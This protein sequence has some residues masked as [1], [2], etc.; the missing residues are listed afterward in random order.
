MVKDSTGT[1]CSY[2]IGAKLVAQKMHAGGF[3][4]VFA[5]HIL[6][7][8]R[9]NTRA[10]THLSPDLA[11]DTFEVLASITLRS[12]ISSYSSIKVAL[13]FCP[14]GSRES[15]SYPALPEYRSASKIRSTRSISL[16]LIA[17]GCFIFKAQSGIAANYRL[18]ESFCE[19]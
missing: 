10:I 4:F 16:N 15:C 6:V 12:S 13:R 1:Q 11:L 19:P 8:H 3:F 18:R 5:L 7:G 17:D 9:H 2:I 14:S